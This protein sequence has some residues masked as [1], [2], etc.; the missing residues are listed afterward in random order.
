MKNNPTGYTNSVVQLT[1]AAPSLTFSPEDAGCS[2]QANWTGGTVTLPGPLTGNPP[3]GVQPSNGDKYYVA[4]PR[5]V[6]VTGNKTLTINGGGFSF[7]SAGALVTQMT[8]AGAAS[9]GFSGVQT[10]TAAVQSLC[11][12]FTFDG[13]VWIVGYG[14]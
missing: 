8:L 10:N 3:G 6:I 2:I 14:Q 11:L 12:C 4:D 9:G 1:A 5:N 13:G 7:W